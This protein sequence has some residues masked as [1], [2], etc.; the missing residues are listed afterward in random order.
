MPRSPPPSREDSSSGQPPPPPPPQPQPQRNL[1]EQE[2]DSKKRKRLKDLKGYL[3]LFSV[4]LTVGIVF[5]A[6][7]D[8]FF[9]ALISILLPTYVGYLVIRLKKRK[10]GKKKYCPN[11]GTSNIQLLE[12]HTKKKRNSRYTSESEFGIY[13]C[14]NCG[15]EF[16]ALRERLQFEYHGSDDFDQ[17]EKEYVIIEE[18]EGSQSS[19]GLSS[20][21]VKAAYYHD[22][23]R[24]KKRRKR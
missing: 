23:V 13:K 24:R 8:I 15:N 10:L 16:E 18:D 5:L 6:P 11:C 17:P 4:P 21:E 20:K 1:T 12:T 14:L 7:E 9:L 3:V 2:I 22:K 19:Q